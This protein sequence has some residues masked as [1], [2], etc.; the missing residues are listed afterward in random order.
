[1]PKENMHKENTDSIFRTALYQ[2]TTPDELYRELLF[3]MEN[4]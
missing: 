1:M 2:E 3:V 4:P